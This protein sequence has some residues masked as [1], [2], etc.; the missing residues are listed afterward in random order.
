MTG[1]ALVT[2]IVEILVSALTGIGT[3]IG[4][5]LSST[6]S[7]LLF[8]TASGGTTSLSPFAIVV[9]AFMGVSLGFT[10]CRWVVNVFTSFGNRAR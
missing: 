6:M 8:V 5:S 3:A 2:A 10:L 1:T 4:E 7:S 9:I